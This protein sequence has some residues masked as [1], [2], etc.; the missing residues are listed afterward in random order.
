MLYM[1]PIQCLFTMTYLS[2]LSLH[3]C[4]KKL[5]VFCIICHFEVIYCVVATTCCRCENGL[6]SYVNMKTS[7]QF[8][9]TAEE[10]GATLLLAHCSQLIS[11]HWVRWHFTMAMFAISCV[12]WDLSLWRFMFGF[13]QSLSLITGPAWLLHCVYVCHKL[14]C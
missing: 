3:Y 7:I 10:M 4:F 11:N 1:T 2:R 14:H 13:V 6:M 12:G 5:Q 8:Y 9:Q